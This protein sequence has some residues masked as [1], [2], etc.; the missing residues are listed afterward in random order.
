MIYSLSS[1]DP[2]YYETINVNINI[3][4]KCKQVKYYVSNI[5]TISNFLL[6]T[7]EDFLLIV[8]D[9]EEYNISFTNKTKLSS[10]TKLFFYL[11]I[12]ENI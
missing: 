2:E 12:K 6:T 8:M 7:N 10:K 5:I 3:P 11:S 1:S 9:G 4:W